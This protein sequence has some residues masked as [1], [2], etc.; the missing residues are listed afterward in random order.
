MKV[1][2]FIDD[3]FEKFFL[4]ILLGTM[5]LVISLQVFMRY[6]FRASLSWSEELARYIFIWMIYIG[7]SYGVKLNRHIKVDAF[8]LLLP[9]RGKKWGGVI[10]NLIFLG[11]AGLIVYQSAGVRAMIG[12]LGQ[13]SPAMGIP[14]Q[15]VYTAVPAGFCLV[16]FR[17]LQNLYCQ[18]KELAASASA[19]AKVGG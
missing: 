19:D 13:D 8:L 11:F 3:N 9:E 15:W 10:S 17:L 2:R 4:I 5:A 14:L 18:I 16:I 7:I 12:E 6:V 1:L